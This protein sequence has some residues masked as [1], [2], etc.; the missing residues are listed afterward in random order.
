MMS[1]HDVSAMMSVQWCHA[2]MSAQWCQH[3]DVSAMM[4]LSLQYKVV[5]TA[6]TAS[7][8]PRPSQ[9]PPSSFWLLAVCKNRG[10]RPGPHYDVNDVSAYLHC[11]WTEG[12]G[13]NQLKVIAC[14]SGWR[15]THTRNVFFQLVTP[16][17]LRLHIGTHWHLSRDKWTR[18]SPSVFAYYTCSQTGRWEIKTSPHAAGVYEWKSHERSMYYIHVHISM[19]V[20]LC[21]G[22]RLNHWHSQTQAWLGKRLNH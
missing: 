22:K 20:T 1:V 5:H 3:N 12:G 8:I 6:H 14:C 2:M 16:P 10:G 13:G 9:F 11:G 7:L 18:S 21:P 19:S 15:T 4:S 17:F